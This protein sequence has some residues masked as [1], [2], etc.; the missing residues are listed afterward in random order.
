MVGNRGLQGYGGLT[1]NVAAPIVHG[2][3]AGLEANL[4][5]QFERRGGMPELDLCVWIL[6]GTKGATTRYAHYKGSESSAN[7][8]SPQSRVSG[9]PI[10]RSTTTLSE[11]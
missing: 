1:S 4:R 8:N 5:K 7:C 3:V 11:W 10:S 6:D 9:S 2:D